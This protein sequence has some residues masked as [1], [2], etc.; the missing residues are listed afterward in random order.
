MS[1]WKRQHA[2][3]AEAMAQHALIDMVLDEFAMN[4]Q[5]ERKG[6][7]AYGLAKIVSCVAQVVLARARGID[8]EMLRLSDAEVSDQHRVLIRHFYEAGKPVI[9]VEVE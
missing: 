5:F 9:V 4:M 6:L 8:P 2:N 3:E 7:R 1:D